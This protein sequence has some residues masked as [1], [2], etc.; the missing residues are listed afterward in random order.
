MTFAVAD[1]LEQVYDM[2]KNEP[3]L[4]W[5]CSVILDAPGS[6]LELLDL[7]KAMAAFDA[8]R[9][10]GSTEA[11]LDALTVFLDDVRNGLPVHQVHSRQGA[12][13]PVLNRLRI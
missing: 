2:F 3:R 8:Y 11:D 12:L 9:V 10:S 1:E 13:V 5:P 7:C 6:S 4:A